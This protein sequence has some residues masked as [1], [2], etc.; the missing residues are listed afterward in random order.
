MSIS[1]RILL[2]TILAAGLVG[3]QIVK[4]TT[5]VPTT[6]ANT[7]LTASVKQPHIL[8]YGATW[9]PNCTDL[10][11]RLREQGRPFTVINIDK[12]PGA[13]KEMI[14]KSGASYVP[15][16]YVDGKFIG[17]GSSL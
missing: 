12:V 2:A 13:Q 9:C 5:L 10:E 7:T 15:Q 14:R 4:H 8:I 6:V 16:V 3:S 1:I 11:D 17:S